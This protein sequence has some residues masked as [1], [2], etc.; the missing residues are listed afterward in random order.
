MDEK[1]KR[2]LHSCTQIL[3]FIRKNYGVINN[4]SQ[5]KDAQKILDW[6]SKVY[7]GEAIP[8]WVDIILSAQSEW[9]AMGELDIDGPGFFE[10]PS[11]VVHIRS[12]IR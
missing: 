10:K 6:A 3:D 12:K 1:T 5:Y 4:K 7:D 8:E 11:N 9:A 2:M